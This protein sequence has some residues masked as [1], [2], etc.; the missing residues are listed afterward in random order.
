MDKTTSNIND[1]MSILF[2]FFNNNILK[3]K[4]IYLHHRLN[5]GIGILSIFLQEEPIQEVKVGYLKHD[6]LPDEMKKDLDERMSKN[7]SNI[8]YFY[9]NTINSA[10]IVETDIRD[11]K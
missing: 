1:K 5:D 3:M 8:I 6:I 9:L 2:G 10:T 7:N 4:D 11:I